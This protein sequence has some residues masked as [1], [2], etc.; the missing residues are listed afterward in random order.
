MQES[1]EIDLALKM[2]P[3]HASYALVGKKVMEVWGSIT[4]LSNC[5]P[6][7]YFSTA[8]LR[9]NFFRKFDSFF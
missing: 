7:Y 2:M 8:I 5:I 4:H 1:G 6:H 9:R 3:E